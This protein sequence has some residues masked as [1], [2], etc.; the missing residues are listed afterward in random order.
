MFR[1]KFVGHTDGH[2]HDY[3]YYIS[4]SLSMGDDKCKRGMLNNLVILHLAK[5]AYYINNTRLADISNS[6]T[7][8]I[9]EF[10]SMQTLFFTVDRKIFRLHL[11]T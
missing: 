2:T 7:G 11:D 5:Y 10:S 9:N 3:F 1:A 4:P 8:I 6:G